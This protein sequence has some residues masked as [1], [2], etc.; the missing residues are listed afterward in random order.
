LLNDRLRRKRV[1]LGQE[2]KHEVLGTDL[3]VSCC[4]C[5][6]L[7]GHHDVPGPL[8]EAVE[9]LVGI[10]IGAGVLRHEALAG[11]LFG[12]A[13]APAD[14]CPGGPGTTCLVDE[15][16]DEMVRH[17]TEV[18]GRQHGVGELIE[19]VRVHLLDGFDQLVEPDRV[20][21][22]GRCCHATT[23]GCR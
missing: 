2:A 23:V 8:G 18:V 12:D 6:V 14:V 20:G 22:A 1:R 16:A 4:A 21:H 10:Q 9:S 5:F 3:A 11:R 19:S 13:H 17:V 15:V 7:R